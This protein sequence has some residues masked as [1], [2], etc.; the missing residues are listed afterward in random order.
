MKKTLLATAALFAFATAASAGGV[1][2]P[3]VAPVEPAA[4]VDSLSFSYGQDFVLDNFGTKDKDTFSATYTHKFGGGYSA[5][6][7]ISTSQSVDSLLKQ[8]I[9]VQGGYSRAITAGLTVG[10]KIGV[11]ERFTETN[12][13]YYAVY[14]ATDYKVNDK[15]TVN[16][17]GYRYRDAFDS[18][19][20]Y[21]SH[22]LST[23]VTYALNTS[24]SVNAK[25]ARNYDEDFNATGDAATVGLTI[26][27]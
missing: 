7:A 24:Y 14:S 26:K 4:S 16:A 10:V 22:Q 2:E 8:N 27:F 23:G 11:G 9:E 18:A 5:G 19:N 6:A 12:F 13:P 1:A 25:F 17:L 3:A 21:K 15:L 20:D